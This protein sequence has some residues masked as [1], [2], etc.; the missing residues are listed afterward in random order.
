MAFWMIFHPSSIPIALQS[1]FDMLAR[2][3]KNIKIEFLDIILLWRVAMWKLDARPRLGVRWLLK[4]VWSLTLLMFSGCWMY[5]CV[6]A[7]LSFKLAFEIRSKAHWMY[8]CVWAHSSFKLAF[9]ILD[10][11]GF[12]GQNCNFFVRGPKSQLFKVK[13]L[14]MHL[15]LKWNNAIT[16]H[17]ICKPCGIWFEWRICFYR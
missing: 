12:G 17:S 6:L 10:L 9:E 16:L 2:I 11:K 7:P 8:K 3:E 14:K 4:F 15:S 1:M 13:G 5:R